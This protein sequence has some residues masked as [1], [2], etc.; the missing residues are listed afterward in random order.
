M[1]PFHHQTIRPRKPECGNR[2]KRRELS[3]YEVPSLGTNI[4]DPRSGRVPLYPEKVLDD[5]T[6]HDGSRYQVGMLWA[7]DESV[8]PNN[9]FFGTRPVKSLEC[10]LA[11]DADLK[12]RYSKTIQDDFS[13]GYIVN[14]DKGD[15]LKVKEVREWFLPHHP[16]VHPHK[17]GTVRR[18]LNGT[19]KFQG[20]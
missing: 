9:F 16:V 10:R 11:K 6:Y 18:M 3:E 13:K 2:H 20:P 15:C 5:T 1:L 7:E 12:E 4:L 19:A 14:V 17:P 8:F